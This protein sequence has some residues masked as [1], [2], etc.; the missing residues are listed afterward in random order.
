MKVASRAA[1]RERFGDLRGS[2]EEYK[3]VYA[4]SGHTNSRAMEGMFRI[5]SRLGVDSSTIPVPVVPK[6]DTNIK[7]S[8]TSSSLDTPSVASTME[9]CSNCERGGVKLKLCSG[10]GV[11][12]SL[13]FCSKD[14]HTAMWKKSHKYYCKASKKRIEIGM[15][16][17]IQGLQTA[18]EHNGKQGRVI[19]LLEDKGRFGV[20]I[21]DDGSSGSNTTSEE[22][23]EEKE[24]EQKHHSNGGG[25]N[26]IEQRGGI[27]DR[28]TSS[29]SSSTTQ[30][31]LSVRPENLRK[32]E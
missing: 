15:T 22:E 1:C 26:I 2:F 18:T 14:C 9:R 5:E 20:E 12:S 10:C 30:I 25:D 29:S 4:R 7:R 16:V 21:I 8:T 23:K 19:R 28:K 31:Q 24:E 6:I 32:K 11:D 3:F 17:V 13:K 27:I